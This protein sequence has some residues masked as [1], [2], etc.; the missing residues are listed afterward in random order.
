MGE[1]RFRNATRDD[2]P[3][4]VRLLAD[5]DLGRTRERVAEPL[6]RPYL[7]AFERAEAQAGNRHIVA[8][9]DGAVV[10]CLQLI[11]LPGLS[12]LGMLRAQLEGIRVAKELRGQGVGTLLL[13]Y[14]IEE[15]RREGCRLVQLTSDLQRP[16][17]QRLYQKLGFHAT[18][19]GM[20]LRL[21]GSRPDEEH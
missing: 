19:I 20:K 5:D 3:A 11:I 13:R 15:A 14:A 1:I 21:A 9:L 10:A 12:R 17:T 16:E 4:I 6:P 2:L 18:H 8:E 7:E